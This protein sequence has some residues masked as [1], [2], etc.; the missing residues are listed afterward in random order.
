[1]NPDT[2]NLDVDQQQAIL[3]MLMV[4]TTQSQLLLLCLVCTFIFLTSVRATEIVADGVIHL[5]K[6]PNEPII[7]LATTSL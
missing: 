1:M 5:S 3:I 7:W 6:K 4:Q 2:N